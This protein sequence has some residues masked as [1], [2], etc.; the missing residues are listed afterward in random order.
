V[1][2]AFL[3]VI[4]AVALLSGATA[5][6]AGFGIGSMLTPLLALRLGMQTAVQRRQSRT[7]RRP[8]GVRAHTRGVRR[9][10]D[11]RGLD[12]GCWKTSCLSLVGGP[13]LT[14]WLL[15]ISLASVGVLA[16][17]LIG[18]HILLGLSRERF[19]QVIGALIG[20][21]GVWLLMQPT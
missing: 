16:G 6:V 5:A 14:A 12:G 15:P 8:H 19:R 3:S 13:R 4:F 7:S 10:F 18:E 1:S 11:R 20:L 2:A 21:L 17:T 9:D